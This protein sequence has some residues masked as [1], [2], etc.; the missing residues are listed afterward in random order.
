MKPRRPFLAIWTP[1]RPSNR[2]IEC[3]TAAL[4]LLFPLTVGATDWPQFRGPSGNGV[5]QEE[6]APLHWGPGKNVRWKAKLPG[7]GNSSP[8][9]SHARVFITCAEDQ[10][11]KRN[12]SC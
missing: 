3:L 7:P 9:A 12:L 2:T 6:K 4:A 5:A 1:C 11:K 10:G 8:I